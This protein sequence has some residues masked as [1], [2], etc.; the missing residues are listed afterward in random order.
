MQRA[1]GAP[2]EIDVGGVGADGD[3]AEG[4]LGE[5]DLVHRE[6]SIPGPNPRLPG[7][8]IRPHDHVAPDQGRQE[9]PMRWLRRQREK[10]DRGESDADNRPKHRG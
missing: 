3:A 5:G 4:T 1:A 9:E 8:P 2:E 7:H 10:R 6:Q